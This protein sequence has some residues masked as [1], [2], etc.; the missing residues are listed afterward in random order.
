MQCQLTEMCFRGSLK[1]CSKNIVFIH[2][3]RDLHINQEAN[4]FVI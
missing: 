2:P 3:R 4:T 1:I